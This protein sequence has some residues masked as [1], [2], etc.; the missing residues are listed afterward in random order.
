MYT[1]GFILIKATLTCRLVYQKS[2]NKR[3]SDTFGLIE[4]WVAAGSVLFCELSTL[5]P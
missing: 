3:D 4:N 2:F 5:D 1:L